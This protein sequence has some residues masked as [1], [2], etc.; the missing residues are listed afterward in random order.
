MNKFSGGDRIPAEVF[1]ILKDDAVKN[2]AFIT[3][4]NLKNSAVATRLE[5]I[6]FHS[7]SKERQKQQLEPEMGQ[8]TGSKLGKRPSKAVYGHSA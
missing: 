2:A 3:P 4:A 5:R 1:Q 7:S 6:S 8:R